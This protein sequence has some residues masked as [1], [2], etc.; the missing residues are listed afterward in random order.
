MS[1]VIYTNR[2]IARNN[3]GRF[4]AECEQAAENTVEDTVSEGADIAAS[5]APKRT[6]RLASSIKPFMLSRT[7][8]VWGSNVPYAAAQEKGAAPHPISAYVSFY[9]HKVGRQWLPPP[10]YERITGRPGADPIQHPGNPA[11]HF[12]RDSQAIMKRRMIQIAKMRYPG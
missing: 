6:L 10:A 9:W 4:I 12:L 7:S 3:F 1:G 8:G 11:R 2:V 5:L